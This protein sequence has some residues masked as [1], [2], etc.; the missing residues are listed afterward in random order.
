MI[1]CLGLFVLTVAY[2]MLSIK[3][4]RL[5]ENLIELVGTHLKM[6]QHIESIYQ[7]LRSKEKDGT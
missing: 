1:V 4:M 7:K 3:V 6:A 2:V 5:S